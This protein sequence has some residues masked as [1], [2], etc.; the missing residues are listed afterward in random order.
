MSNPLNEVLAKNPFAALEDRAD[1][2]IPTATL[3]IYQFID[4]YFERKDDTNVN[5]A[6]SAT[7]CFKR[8]WL[9][10]NGAKG[11]PLT[12]RK[13]VNF[14]LGALSESA[15]LYF[16]TKGCVGPGKL[17]SE[18]D[19]GEEIG[20]INFNG[21]EIKVYK[22]E[23][24]VASIE[25]IMVTAHADGW[26]KRN[27]DGQWELIEC[28]SAADYGFKDFQTT[29]PKDYLKQSTT[30]MMTSK[31]VSLGVKSVRFFYLRKQTGHMW[32]RLYQFDNEL[33]EEVKS[34]LRVVN[35]T[36]EPKTPF[37]LIEEKIRG[38]PTGK[39]I[40]NFPCTYC[41]YIERCQ[42]KYELEWKT[43]Q[44]G[45]MRPNY[46]FRKKEESNEVPS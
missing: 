7:M 40:A 36:E 26:G 14:L 20:S 12:P 28:K 25:G 34:E 18:V 23:D 19:F 16:I 8:R 31:A 1:P 21:K 22:Q 38:K 37:L 42:G 30:V 5:R 46:V 33:L 2:E 27:S 4:E 43:D 44:F 10:K 24:L 3:Q 45:H 39:K 6:S 35:G 29:G 17:Y 15:M 32:D 11:Q 9:Q 41:P 13:Q